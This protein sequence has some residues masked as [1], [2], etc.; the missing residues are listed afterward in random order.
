MRFYGV[1]TAKS[2]SFTELDSALRYVDENG[3]PIV[4][5]LDG[6]AAG[7]GVTVVTSIGEAEVALRAFLEENRFG[8]EGLLFYSR[9][10]LLAKK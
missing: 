3:A 5:E 8:E 4:I 9:N 6:L 2:A 1:P 7:K 10:F